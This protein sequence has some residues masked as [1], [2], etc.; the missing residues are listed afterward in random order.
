M[1]AKRESKQRKGRRGDD[2]RRLR[3]QRKGRERRA[4]QKDRQG[5]NVGVRRGKTTQEMEGG[6]SPECVISRH[7]ISLSRA[8]K[9]NA[10]LCP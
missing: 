10:R 7:S 1:N 6:W 9:R 4:K 8:V 2:E 5:S 3:V